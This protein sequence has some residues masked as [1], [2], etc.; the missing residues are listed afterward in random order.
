MKILSAEEIVKIIDD[1]DFWISAGLD[2]SRYI[3]VQCY[4]V[5]DDNDAI[6]S[7]YQVSLI[8]HV[9]KMQYDG[10]GSSLIESLKDA[11]DTKAETDG[12]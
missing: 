9:S 2:Y 1:L 7:V 8:D 10:N 5:V 6:E 4:Y 3:S 11:L 12:Q